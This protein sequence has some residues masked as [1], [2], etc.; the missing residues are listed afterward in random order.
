MTYEL[1]IDEIGFLTEVSKKL[2]HKECDDEFKTFFKSVNGKYNG[3]Q[4]E[5]FFHIIK[6]EKI[7]MRTIFR[8]EPESDWDMDEVTD[9]TQPFYSELL[10]NDKSVGR[11][12]GNTEVEQPFS[13]H[14]DSRAT[15]LVKGAEDVC[16]F[17][18]SNFE[19]E[20]V[21]F[22]LGKG[23]MLKEINELKR[24][25]LQLENDYINGRYLRFNE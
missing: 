8:F 3:F 18:A 13:N 21:V 10:G 1:C 19:L 22:C 12:I 15:H 14:T 23:K 6:D 4:L 17:I 11:L 24:T 9:S 2:S 20:E 7:T 25:I 5:S 16:K